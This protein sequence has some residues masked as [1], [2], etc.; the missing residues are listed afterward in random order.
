MGSNKYYTLMASLPSL[1]QPFQLRHVPISRLKLYQRLRML[2]EDDAGRLQWIMRLMWWEEQS[3]ETQIDE[4]VSLRMQEIG[5]KL[6]HKS[7][8]EFIR[9]QLRL[10]MVIGA[11]RLRQQNLQLPPINF[12]WGYKDLHRFL[13]E[14]WESPVFGLEYQ[15]PFLAEVLSLL[16][17]RQS[18]AVERLILD[19][20][21][22][23]IARCS[24]GHYFD[25]EAVVFYVLRWHMA[26]RWASYERKRAMRRFDQMVE[27]IL[28][29]RV[30]VEQAF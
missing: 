25:F 4:V 27:T 16:K 30:N 19:Q 6:A 23:K 8:L 14:N 5:V 7:L 10:R 21:W 1:S 2:E 18:L 24:E 11:L 26:A 22:K 20:V 13:L 3:H 15:Y 28:T 29:S 17:S 9:W 12:L